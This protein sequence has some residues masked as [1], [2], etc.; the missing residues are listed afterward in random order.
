VDITCPIAPTI[1]A[2]SVE[3]KDTTLLLVIIL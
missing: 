2:K 1:D 3:K